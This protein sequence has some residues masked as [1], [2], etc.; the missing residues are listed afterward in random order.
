MLEV[1]SRGGTEHDRNSSGGSSACTCACVSVKLINSFCSRAL[2]AK[3]SIELVNPTNYETP[4]ARKVSQTKYVVIFS[5]PNFTVAEP[6]LQKYA[7]FPSSWIILE[8]VRDRE[9]KFQR[10]I[11]FEKVLSHQNYIEKVL[12]YVSLLVVSECIYLTL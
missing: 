11:H 6:A 1:C 8:T 12:G 5:V 3:K 7:N 2:L 10:K 4:R 9:E